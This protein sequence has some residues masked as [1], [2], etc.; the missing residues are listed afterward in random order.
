L[1]QQAT[2]SKFVPIMHRKRMPPTGFAN[3]RKAF[4]RVMAA[5]RRVLT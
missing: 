5:I 2:S 3:D 1:R 4:D